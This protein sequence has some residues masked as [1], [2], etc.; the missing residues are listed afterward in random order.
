MTSF[1]DQLEADVDELTA[2][3]DNVVVS[4]HQYTFQTNVLYCFVLFCIVLYCIVLY[5]SLEKK[6]DITNHMIDMH[7]FYPVVLSFLTHTHAHTQD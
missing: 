6:K 5:G 4:F 3:I 7:C 2:F 1:Q